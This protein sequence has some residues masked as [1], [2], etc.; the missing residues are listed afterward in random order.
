MSLNLPRWPGRAFS[1]G[2]YR[3]RLLWFRL[4][5]LGLACGLSSAVAWTGPSPAAEAVAESQVLGFYEVADLL[6]HANRGDSRLEMLAREATGAALEGSVLVLRASPEGHRRLRDRLLSLRR[7]SGFELTVSARFIE[8]E[9]GFLESLGITLP[10]DPGAQD[11][12]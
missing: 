2:V 4:A 12:R 1:L 10:E 5:L 6:E 9:D 8:V 3:C 7:S 11:E